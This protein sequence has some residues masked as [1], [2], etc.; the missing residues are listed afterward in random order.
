MNPMKLMVLVLASLALIAGSAF[1]FEG[2]FG[3]TLDTSSVVSSGVVDTSAE[4]QYRAAVW[5]EL[6]Q[7]TNKGGSLDLTAQGS[8]RYTAERPY[9]FDLDLFRF[10]GL[11]SAALGDGTAVELKAGRFNFS[12][13]TKL[14]LNQ[15]MDGAQISLLFSGFQVR[16]AGAYSGF[17][18]NPSSNVRISAD[19]QLE[20]NDNSVFFGPK[21]LVAQALLGSDGFALQALAQFDMR[22]NTGSETIDTQ[23]LGIVGT[24]RL[25]PNF[26]LDYNLTAS[27]GQSTVGSKA[28]NLISLLGGFGFR[29]Y[30]EELAGSRAHAE[31]TYATGFTPIVLLLN[32]F[33]LED[34]RPI[35]QPTIGL[36]FSP[37]LANILY[38]DVGYSFRPFVKNPSTV[39]S[40]IEPQ[41]GA[42]IYFR[43]PV[44]FLIT[45]TPA[46]ILVH[47]L[48]PSST[49]LYLGT[50]IEAGVLAR[51]FSDLGVSVRGGVFLPSAGGSNAFT[52][53]RG[54]GFV[55]K[56]E[57]SAAM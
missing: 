43:D 29:F 18:L 14:I 21:R 44:P 27:Y 15:T 30:A 10:T 24:P 8:Y 33:S 39:L 17:L 4:S 38:L 28:T 26:Y 36:A 56:I 53:N 41:V 47:D 9:I 45:G 13:A 16:L 51:I 52:S 50:E 37:R 49:A 1:A 20:A 22:G 34:F 12:D 2:D 32:N 6:F 55:L 35:S 54:I 23:Y 57:A 7:T 5:G 11:F 42:R 31:V 3:V 40:N 19:D 25:T 46:D 48:N